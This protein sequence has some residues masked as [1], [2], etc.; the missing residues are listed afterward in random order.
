MQKKL[1]EE[2]HI[3]NPRP[4]GYRAYHLLLEVDCPIHGWVVAEV[5]VK[6]LLQDS[7]GALTHEDHYK[8]AVNVLENA[9]SKPGDGLVHGLFKALGD[10]LAAT[11]QI[12]QEIRAAILRQEEVEWEE[13]EEEQSQ[14]EPTTEKSKEEEDLVLSESEF[15][16]RY[17]VGDIVKGQV[18]HIPLMNYGAIV[19]LDDGTK[20]LCHISEIGDHHEFVRQIED[21]LT[22]GEV[23]EF[24]IKRINGGRRELQL[25]RRLTRLLPS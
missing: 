9:G 21:H 4:N 13:V 19:L 22:V 5:Q 25:T 17:H 14:S 16:G 24:K 8:S 12:A 6:T 23:Y 10:S 1:R 18:V 7:W 2:D 20:G 3:Q 11:D 15:Q